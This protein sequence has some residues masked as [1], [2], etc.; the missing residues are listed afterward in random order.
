M[1]AIFTPQYL[2]YDSYSMFAMFNKNNI[3]PSKISI[4]PIDVSKIYENYKEYV[5]AK[6]TNLENNIDYIFKIN[7]VYL[8]ISK[9]I[10]IAFIFYNLDDKSVDDIIKFCEGCKVDSNLCNLNIIFQNGSE[11]QTQQFEIEKI[12]LDIKL[13]Y[14]DDFQ[15]VDKI[16]KDKLLKNKKGIILLY[17][18]PGT[19]KTTYIRSL[20]N[21]IDKKIIYLPPDMID[22]LS[23]PHF[24]K[25]LSRQKN[26]ILIIED[27]EN[28]LK[29]RTGDSNQA[30]SNLLNLSDG[31]LSDCLNIQI[32]ATF[33][34]KIDD[35]DSALLR[36]GRLIAK[37]EFKQL[38]PEKAKKLYKHIGKQYQEKSTSLSEIYNSEDIE[39]NKPK[40]R[41]GFV[42]NPSI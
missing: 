1:K 9:E 35:I 32:V 15:E 12:K 38:D 22:S 19:G 26:S 7:N 6:Y 16:I 40:S 14:N 18:E 42:K 25:F 33:N 2:N 5:L 13:N 20:L 37:Y 24:I 4:G 36:K 29:K 30:I 34:C 27:G 31:L 41:I 8:T 39:F 28:V 11:L 23:S 21:T 3:V 10:N 17:G